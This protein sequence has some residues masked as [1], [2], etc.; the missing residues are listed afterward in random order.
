M[1]YQYNTCMDLTL[2]FI[3]SLVTVTKYYLNVIVVVVVFFFSIFVK[4]VEDYKN[5]LDIQQVHSIL[6]V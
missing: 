2:F 4:V 6:N 3:N 1:Q 5:Q